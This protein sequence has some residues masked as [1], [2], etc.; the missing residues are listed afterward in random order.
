MRC[1]QGRAPPFC[2]VPDALF[3]PCLTANVGLTNLK[4][5]L[6]L[7]I[8]TTIVAAALLLWWDA[9]DG[10]RFERAMEDLRELSSDDLKKHQVID[11]WGKPYLQVEAR[12]GDRAATYLISQGPDGRTRMLGHDSDDIAT[13][14][15]RFEWLAGLHPVRWTWSILLISGGFSLASGVMMSV[16]RHARKPQAK[17]ASASDGDKPQI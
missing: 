2:G 4:A 3:P 6:P 11:P 14:K 12:S 5:L 1:R 8:L 7:S 17:Q 16:R 10:T 15:S 9:A 13:W